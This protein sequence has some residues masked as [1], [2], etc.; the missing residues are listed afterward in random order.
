MTGAVAGSPGTLPTNWNEALGGLTRQIIGTGT[1][2]DVNYIDIRLSG[3]ATVAQ[4]NIR[5]ETTT[6]I[7]AA[8]GQTWSNSWFVKK[9][10]EP[11]PP[12]AYQI[13]T[14]ERTDVG[15]GVTEGGAA[16]APTT[17]AFQRFT[18]TRTLS[19]GGTVARVQPAIN[20][21]LTIGQSYD[22][23]VRLG[24]PQMETGSVATSPIVT[25]AGT[26]S[27]VADVVSLTGASSL[28]G[29]TEGTLYTEITIPDAIGVA[30]VFP[31]TLVINSASGQN[32]VVIL[33]R[34]DGTKTL[35]F[36]LFA[37][38]VA[39]YTRDILNQSGTLKIAHSYKTGDSNFYINGVAVTTPSADAY[40]FTETMDNIGLGNQAG[41]AN[42]TG[43]IRSA[44]LF[45]T[46]LTNAQ[47]TSL[48]TL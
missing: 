18:Q 11:L 27:R 30:S 6:A 25:T 5:P 26:A 1:E 31:R 2:L 13:L 29:Q 46:R 48:T 9:I 19:G 16:I 21:T 38:N 28:I 12:I 22:F 15:G 4:A 44:V 7:V 34:I 43:W 41:G 36:Q 17:S 35:R 10:A 47:L 40:T 23:T 37:N 32:R 14:I 8:T 33:T 24:W 42:M 39:I 20:F 45:P 3:T